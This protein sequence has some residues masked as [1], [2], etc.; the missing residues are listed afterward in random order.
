MGGR[1]GPG[2]GPAE[3]GG[4]GCLDRGSAEAAKDLLV[5]CADVFF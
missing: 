3:L 5:H 2:F 4:V 1:R